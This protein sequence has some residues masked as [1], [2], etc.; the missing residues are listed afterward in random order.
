M[1]LIKNPNRGLVCGRS[2]KRG[3]EDDEPKVPR[4]ACSVDGKRDEHPAIV[5]ATCHGRQL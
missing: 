3:V 2:G 5:I 1:G 4:T